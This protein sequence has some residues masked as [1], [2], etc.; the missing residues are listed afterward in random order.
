MRVAVSGGMMVEP[1]YS[2]SDCEGLNEIL[3]LL[4]RLYPHLDNTKI[5]RAVE[6]HVNKVMS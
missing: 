3:H 1:Y 5:L 4:S 2:R 6:S